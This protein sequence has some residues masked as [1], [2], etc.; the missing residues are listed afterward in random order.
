MASDPTGCRSRPDLNGVRRPGC[1]QISPCTNACGAHPRPDFGPASTPS[2]CFH[3]PT[4][5]ANSSTTTSPPRLVNRS[6]LLSN[7]IGRIN[8]GRLA[9]IVHPPGVRLGFFA[10]SLYHTSP[11]G[12]RL[13]YASSLPA[14]AIVGWG[15]VLPCDL[16]AG[17]RAPQAF[18][19]DP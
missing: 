9:S 11:E 5:R 15:T 12:E 18:I 19:A 7:L 17:S 8:C 1:I 6:E 3:N 2:T 10:K 4:A 13:F 14:I 16:G